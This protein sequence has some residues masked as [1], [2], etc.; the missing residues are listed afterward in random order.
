[1]WVQLYDLC[2]SL[3]LVLLYDLGFPLLCEQLYDFYFPLVLVL[4]YDLWFP[5][6]WVPLCDLWLPLVLVQLA[7]AFRYGRDDLDVINLSFKRHIWSQTIQVYPVTGEADLATTPTQEILM[8]KAGDQ[9][10]PFT[11]TVP[12]L[13]SFLSYSHSSLFI[14][15]CQF[16]FFLSEIYTWSQ[17]QENSFFCQDTIL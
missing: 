5:L 13:S 12:Q 14:S 15:H 10:H 17:V 1:M 4:L 2:F 8:K 3:M 9:G 7:C 16:L 11:F 6:V